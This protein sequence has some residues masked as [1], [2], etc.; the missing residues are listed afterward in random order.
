M[1]AAGV[2]KLGVLHRLIEVCTSTH[3]DSQDPDHRHNALMDLKALICTPG[4]SIYIGEKQKILCELK[5]HHG[6][7]NCLR[8]VLEIADDKESHAKLILQ[9][10]G[11]NHER[12]LE[13]EVKNVASSLYPP[14]HVDPL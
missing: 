8:R 9:A 7:E 1:S 10:I 4:N 6:F 2:R 13:L 11:K 3:P 12:Q 5:D 14:S